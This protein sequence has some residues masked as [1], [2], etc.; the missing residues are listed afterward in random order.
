MTPT[1]L[2]LVESL[3]SLCIKKLSIWLLH[4]HCIF[5][6][7]NEGSVAPKYSSTVMFLIECTA[8][9][10]FSPHDNLCLI[11]ASITS[12][13]KLKAYR[14][15]CLEFGLVNCQPDLN[16]AGYRTY[17]KSSVPVASTPSTSNPAN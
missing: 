16:Q 12:V 17:T 1:R 15:T 11:V 2:I 8:Q 6:N 9:S 13:C 5:V 14:V 4:A 10:Q 7:T 3:G